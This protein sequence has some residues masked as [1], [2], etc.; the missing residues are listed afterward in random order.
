M[1]AQTTF[2]LITIQYMT[3]RL[4]KIVLVL[5]LIGLP[6]LTIQ[7]QWQYNANQY[8]FRK[9]FVEQRSTVLGS[10]CYTRLQFNATE[11]G[12]GSTGVIALEFTVAPVSSINKFDF[13]YFEGPDAPVNDQKLMRVTLTGDGNST[14]HMLSLSG[15][16]SAEV[17]D[18]FVFSATNL[19][20]EK[21]G[22]VRQI[23]D[24]L[25][26]VSESIEVAIIDGLDYSVVLSAVFPLSGGKPSFEALLDGI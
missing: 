13:G 25:L 23:L 14:V 2:T 26:K 20:R 19:T 10:D 1:F 16:F 8:G 24:Q 15:W 17:D 21:Q 9:A 6:L 5:A 4:I 22:Q 3:I 18:G 7:A 12:E 11:D